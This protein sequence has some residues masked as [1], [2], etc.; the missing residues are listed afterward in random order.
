MSGFSK[1]E[2]AIARFF[3]QFPQLKKAIKKIYQYSN[4]LL[5]RKGY[6]FRAEGQLY[7]L[8][9]PEGETFFG[10]Y[11]KSP[12]S[13]D[14]RYLLFHHTIFPT[15]NLPSAANP[16]A[17]CV[18]D[19]KEGKLIY[20]AATR[21][22]NWQQGTKLQ[23]L[24]NR[25]FIYNNYSEKLGY[26]SIKV[27]LLAQKA[28]ESIISYPIYD[29]FGEEYG[30]SLSFERLQKLRPDY[31]YRNHNVNDDLPGYSE[32]GIFYVDLKT[33]N[34]YLLLS[35]KEIINFNGTYIPDSADHKVNHIMIS[36]DGQHFMFLHRYFI[37]RQRFDRLMVS[38]IHGKHLRVL[39]DDEMV[40][41]CY[42]INN[43]EI[44]SYL[45]DFKTGD[46]YYRL[47]I[48][49]NQKTIVGEGVIDQFGDGHPSVNQNSII[50]DTYPNKARM[51]ELYTYQMDE[52][53]LVRLGE[54]F[55]N[56]NYYGETRCDL[57]PRFSFDG[58][59]I[60][61]DSVH[62]GK[63]HLYWLKIQ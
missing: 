12:L 44:I 30:L 19:L 26:H 36:P 49:T 18:W 27:E 33:G 37:N 22:Y 20:R 7:K 54:F 14:S 9:I 4:F 17:V 42:W 16:I 43:S 31:G 50:F 62:E 59:T 40:S 45:R 24:T 56:M 6:T 61:I 48:R 35:L 11:D 1:R 28:E 25:K 34:I 2:R 47:D 13:L 46:K 38:D 15:V 51:K 21:A 3:S 10:Y 58:K 57:H 63:R 23:W 60:F 32:D 55:E 53:K 52:H 39:A 41:H 29:C 5:Y 8:P